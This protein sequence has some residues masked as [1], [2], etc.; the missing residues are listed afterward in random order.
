[1]ARTLV[2]QFAVDRSLDQLA[3]TEDHHRR[4][5]VRFGYEYRAVKERATDVHPQWEKVHHI[6]EALRE[7]YDRVVWLDADAYWLGESR[8]LPGDGEIHALPEGPG[9]YN[10]GVLYFRNTERLRAFVDAWWVTPDDGHYNR[11][12]HGFNGL[13]RDGSRN[14]SVRVV[15]MAKRYN[16]FAENAN[17]RSEAR[18]VVTAWHGRQDRAGKLGQYKAFHYE[19]WLGNAFRRL[20]RWDNRHQLGEV[21]W[22]IDASVV[23]EVGVFEAAFTTHLAQAVAAMDAKVYGYD[24]WSS[25]AGY[26]DRKNDAAL[27]QRARGIAEERALAAGNIVLLEMDGGEAAG[28]HD[29]RSCDLV[30]L[31]ANHSYESVRNECWSWW[32]RVRA[33]GVL[34][35]HDYVNRDGLEV[36]RAVDE[37]SRTVGLP[38]FVSGERDWPSWAIIKPIRG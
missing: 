32:S 37:F 8:L 22:E 18:P 23:V 13:L 2:L 14:C 19:D 36:V 28:Q 20:K 34:C 29:P 24:L 12:Q 7:G 31:D 11:D 30:Y 15:P 4:A 16:S 38:V 35:G 33:G 21:L 26:K 25:Y 1:M 10:T 3:V 17:Y 27:L 6:R 9:Q 5:C